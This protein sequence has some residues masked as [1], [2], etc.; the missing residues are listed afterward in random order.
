VEFEETKL[1]ARFAEIRLVPVADDADAA[2]VEGQGETPE[3]PKPR[4]HV[5]T[6]A[7]DVEGSFRL[8]GV[9]VGDYVA[10]A[11]LQG[12]VTP[13]TLAAVDIATEEQTKR[14]IA[15]MPLVHV[16]AGQVARVNVS[17]RRGAV[18][19][20]RVQFA[21]GS[22]A[23]GMQVG[24]ELA[25]RDLAMESVRLARPSRLQEIARTFDYDATHGRKIVA[26]EE[27]RFRVA[28][29][30]PGKYIVSTMIVSQLGSGEVMMSDGSGFR[31][32]SQ[33]RI[34]PNMTTVYGP[35]VFRRREA[36]VFEIRGQEQVTD[37]DVKI[38]MSG[39][40]TIRG[41]I[42]AGEDRHTPSQAMIRL[43][44][45]GRDLP[46]LA[47]MEDGG[48]FQINYLP[49]GSYTLS[50]IG[51][52]YAKDAANATDLPREARVYQQTKI[53]VVVGG[54]DVM[55]GDVVLVAL[56]PGEKMEY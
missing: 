21:D 54:S 51:S 3:K 49:S 12:Y 13:G 45:D 5:V 30:S 44:E 4:V 23:T 52:D 16:E 38:D 18:I 46:L 55:V 20:G 24:L 14:L 48:S 50:V 29:L 9:P 28:G 32:S 36:K 11:L 27:G 33:M 22:P 53:P 37:A 31:S 7:S 26:D 34:Y 6:G 10:G 40:H 47:T 35:G 17:L 56:K 41:R 1:P 42:L 15:S 2:H 43:K 25:E 19:S 39:L 8:D